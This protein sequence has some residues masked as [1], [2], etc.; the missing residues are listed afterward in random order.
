MLVKLSDARSETAALQLKNIESALELY[1]LDTG[2]YPSN[3]AGA[4]SLVEQPPNSVGWH[5]P[6]LKKESG[7]VD[8]WGK[9]FVY[10]LPG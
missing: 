8:P 5:G 10:R 6:Y 1:Y 2:Q 3:E 9:E 4:R 7:L